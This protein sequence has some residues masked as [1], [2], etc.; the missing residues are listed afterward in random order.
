MPVF[1][2]TIVDLQD[3]DGT[4]GETSGNVL[5][6]MKAEKQ[7]R[8]RPL[9]VTEHGLVVDQSNVHRILRT[10]LSQVQSIERNIN[11]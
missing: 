7:G 1:D 6:T 4:L 9:R 8:S 5:F 3:R 10:I 2:G 11:V